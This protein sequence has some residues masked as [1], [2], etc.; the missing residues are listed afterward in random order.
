MGLNHYLAVRDGL[1]SPFFVQMRSW[2][3]PI[4]GD[5]W[6]R[7]A[8]GLNEWRAIPDKSPATR[9]SSFPLAAA[10]LHTS[11]LDLKVDLAHQM[12][13]SCGLCPHHCLVNRNNG[14]T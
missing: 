3:A 4:A 6:E 12:M 10:T 14:E 9:S 7:H 5:L 2:S 1:R 13:D 8:A 11:L